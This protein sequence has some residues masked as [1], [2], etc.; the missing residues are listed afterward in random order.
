[1]DNLYESWMS[2]HDYSRPTHKTV[3]GSFFLNE[4]DIDN[5]K[6]NKGNVFFENE[7]WEI[8][9][10]LDNLQVGLNRVVLVKTI[11]F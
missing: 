1:M 2:N 5:V 8:D 4:C 6:Q 3:T 9:T 10:N 7:Y 11:K